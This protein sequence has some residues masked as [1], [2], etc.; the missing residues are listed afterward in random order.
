MARFQLGLYMGRSVA[1]VVVAVTI[2]VVVSLRMGVD[3]SMS[4]RVL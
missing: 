1:A 4:M 2:P 3:E